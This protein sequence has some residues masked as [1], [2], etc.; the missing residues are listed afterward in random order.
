MVVYGVEE[1]LNLVEGFWGPFF[2]VRA[3]FVRTFI[4]TMSF[5]LNVE[6][7]ILL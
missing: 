7:L 6:C 5:L 2:V 1:E 4:I 3:S